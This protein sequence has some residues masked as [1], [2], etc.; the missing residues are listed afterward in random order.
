MILSN[1]S[2]PNFLTIITIIGYIFIVVSILGLNKAWSLFYH[3]WFKMNNNKPSKVYYIIYFILHVVY[4]VS[5]IL[6]TYIL[7]TDYFVFIPLGLAIVLALLL[8]KKA[9]KALLSTFSNKELIIINSDLTL[10]NR[11]NSVLIYDITLLIF[12]II[13]VSITLLVFLFL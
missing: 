5:I 3:V 11:L 4:L 8:Y 2:S 13:G 9:G 12:T 6:Y 10:I 7:L 1:V